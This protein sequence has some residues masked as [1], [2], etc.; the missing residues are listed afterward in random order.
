M[1]Q[2]DAALRMPYHDN[3]ASLIQEPSFV[4][5]VGSTITH[6]TEYAQ[7]LIDSF[8]EAEKPPH[9]AISVDMLDTGIDVP[10]VVNLV[11]FKRVRSKT[12]FWQMVG[13]GTRLCP[14]LF[15]PD[16]DKAFFYI[17]DFCE[18]LEFFSQ[19]PETVEG[20]LADSVGAK[21][22]KS[23]LELIGA[24]QARDDRDQELL[25][26]TRQ[27]LQSQVAGM[28]LDN[29]VVRPH[30]KLVEKYAK[31]EAWTSLDEADKAVLGKTVAGLPTSVQDND[32]AA[33]GFDLIVL[34]LQLCLLTG[35]GG[36]E[37]LQEHI[38]TLV[39]ALQEKGSI[40]LVKAQMELIEAVSGDEWW[41]DVTV[42]MLE[43][44]RKRLR[45]SVCTNR[46]NGHSVVLG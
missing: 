43:A 44:M 40:P 5:T 41:Q 18:N 21:L 1:Y 20:S 36:L 28:P 31:P 23:R 33:K 29:F 30:R 16:Q 22:F 32:Q 46:G 9:I 3:L 11:F 38:R 2:N 6:K 4:R 15:G 37:K 35:Q 13:R 10:E 26:E 24:L 39:S 8:S 19:N 42:G 25:R 17:F 14:D 34:R 27:V 45:D 7:N 12:K